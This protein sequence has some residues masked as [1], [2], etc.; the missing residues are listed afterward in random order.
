MGT[1]LQ[2]HRRSLL[3]LLALLAA[4]GMIAALRLPV[5]LFPPIAFPRIVASVDAGDRPVDR[6]VVEVTRPLEQALRAV[7]A[8]SAIR[9]TSSR[10]SAE[11][12]VSFSWGTDMTTALLQVESALNQ[13]L[14]ALPPGVRVAA[15][16]MDPTIFPV[17]G[18]ALT[19]T[20]SDLVALRNVAYYQLRPVVSAIPG[21]ARVEVLGGQRAEYHVLVDAARLQAFGLSSGDVVGGLAANS[22]ASAV[23]RIEDRYRLYLVL[24]DARLR[25]PEDIRNTVLTSG[26]DG[27]VKVEDVA[28]VESGTVPEWT[29]VT[30]NGRDAVLLN[31]IQQRDANTVALVAA[32]KSTLSAFRLHVPR[33]VQI[34]PYYDQ[35]TLVT[36][37]A[38]SVRDAIFIG[39]G[40]AAL[41]LLVFLRNLRT[42]VIIALVLPAVLAITAV[43]LRLFGMSL[44][45]MTLGGMAAAVGLVVDDGVVMLEHIARRLTEEAPGERPRHG[46]I[47]AAGLEMA[48]PLAG[49]SLATIVVFAPLALLGGVTGGFFKALAVTMAS[50]LAISFVVAFLVVPVLADV[51]LT[52]GASE[53]LETA[54]RLLR[55]VQRR[56]ARLLH[57]SLSWPFWTVPAAALLAGAGYLSYSQLGTGFIPRM[58]EGGFIVDYVAP[59]GTSLSETDRLL[60]EVERIVTSI[61]EVD[62]YSRR[63]G[64]Q[65]GGGLTEANTG[66]FF[67]HLKPPPRR[68][69]EAVMAEVRR[70]V[71]HEVP[72]LRIETAQLMEDL[73]GDLT[74]V[75]QPIEIKLFGDDGAQLR[76][77]AP[78][79]AARL[80]RVSGVV[81]PFDGVRIAGNAVDIRV[82]R[83]K[84]ALEGVGADLVTRQVQAQLAGTVA[85]VIQEGETL[86]GVRVWS[87]EGARRYLQQLQALRL[88]APDGHSMPLSRVATAEIQGGQAEVVREN[89]KP[90]VAV[91]ARVEGRDLGS[92]LRD[93]RAALAPLPLPPGVYVEYGGLYREQQQS[94]RDLLLVFVS[95]VMLVTVLLLFLYERVAVVASI[96]ITTLLSTS[97][98]FAGLW[99]T[100][101]E[102][103]ISALVGMT[104]IVGIVTEVAIF[105]F[106]EL[107]LTPSAE[108]SG[109]VRAGTMRMRPILMTTLIAILALLPLALNIGAGAAMQK[110]LAIA[111]I[112]GLVVAVPLVLLFMPALYAT[113]ERVVRRA[114]GLEASDESDGVGA[115]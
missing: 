12:S 96:L 110:P 98:V 9:S 56:Y 37:A 67:L 47:L 108:L 42:T 102:L 63:T 51:L 71:E 61:P 1:W 15:H 50:A 19:S 95:A 99:L 107:G 114:D 43:A 89:L 4:G 38:G 115:G 33:D 75:P 57:W 10:G 48:R 28:R 85:S 18:L 32:V 30:A 72:G 17:L 103:D 81:E 53:R 34:T 36:A 106:A 80:A 90:M 39:A 113:L 101:T 91:T 2:R 44:N 52:R 59:P 31:V 86:V 54:G 64:L 6:M 104:M 78:Q 11:L 29:R 58:D 76:A 88:R 74:A 70:K 14:P 60:R 45:I 40:L 97:G 65:L 27:V 25:T 84:A 41:V 82:D 22:L 24:S 93:V 13:A 62:S 55:G 79:V 7:P 3:F 73:V 69:I 20:G 23:G 21:V 16:R 68:P 8:V 46:P 112:S 111:I 26:P 87:P 35:S 77:L 94:F 105:Y 66:D 49:S 109:L 100:G 83:V 5:A 92:T